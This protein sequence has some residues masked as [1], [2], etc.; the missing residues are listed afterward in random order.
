MSQE[1]RVHAGGGPVGSSWKASL[2]ESA[3]FVDFESSVH[4]TLRKVKPTALAKL[5]KATNKEIL[6]SI[7]EQCLR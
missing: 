7:F 6:L 4:F 5:V 1:L 2:D 3:S